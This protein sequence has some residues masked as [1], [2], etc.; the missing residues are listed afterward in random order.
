MKSNQ[1]IGWEMPEFSFFKAPVTNTT[2]WCTVTLKF[3]FD[4]IRC[5]DY[6]DVTEAL[7]K[8][9][10]MKERQRFKG[11]RLDF[12]IPSGVFAKRGEKHL[13]RHSGIIVLD[14]DHLE[15]PEHWKGVFQN[16]PALE[17]GLLF[18]S[19]SG[20][21]LKWFI[22]ADLAHISHQEFFRAASSYIYTEYGIMADPSGRDI[23]RC[24]YLCQDA[25]AYL[26]PEF[27]SK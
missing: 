13:L 26:N 20:M 5:D 11:Q 15:N 3:V 14:F 1:K 23:A 17:T 18:K 25:R 4:L 10:D 9:S 24:C 22:L 2:P 7:R 16:D 21:G 8:I 12:I 19:P 27:L 6:H